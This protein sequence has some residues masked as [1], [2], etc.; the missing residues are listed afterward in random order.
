MPISYSIRSP[1]FH[2]RVDREKFAWSDIAL[3]RLAID[4]DSRLCIGPLGDAHVDR[5]LLRACHVNLKL[6]CVRSWIA[7]VLSDGDL[8]TVLHPS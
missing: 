2:V 7:G 4:G 3:Y 6:S 1:F 8:R 5:E